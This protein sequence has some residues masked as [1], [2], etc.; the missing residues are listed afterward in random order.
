MKNLISRIIGVILTIANIIALIILIKTFPP[1]TNILIRLYLPVLI[2][3][4]SSAYLLFRGYA[5]ENI[6]IKVIIILVSLIGPL[7]LSNVVFLQNVAE[8][9]STNH[10]NQIILE[11]T[12]EWR[13]SHCS[14]TSSKTR[15][16][17]D[18]DTQDRMFDI[19]TC[20]DTTVRYYVND[21]LVQ[22][23]GTRK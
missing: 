18:G 6:V 16:R 4:I 17:L 14:L 21:Q 10:Y 7:S 9:Q 1:L 11:K 13:D 2:S 3:L 20:K 12:P 22:I 5:I 8:N 23:S 15:M 19:Y